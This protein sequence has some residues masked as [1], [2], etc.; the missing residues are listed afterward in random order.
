ME[1][2][3]V[4]EQFLVNN[5]WVIVLAILWVIPWKGVALW[6][7][8]REEKSGWFILFLL[9]NTLGILEI[10]YIFYFSKKK[11]NSSIPKE[12]RR[13]MLEIFKEKEEVKNEDVR[14]VLGVSEATATNYLSAL[15]EEKEIKQVGESGRGVYY[16]KI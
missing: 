10:I 3:K 4:F 6:K 7:S 2:I 8:A 5:P 9:V 14:V 11:K 15:E 16:K 1:E 12:R 13:E